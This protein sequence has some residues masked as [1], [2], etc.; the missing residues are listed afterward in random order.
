MASSTDVCEAMHISAAVMQRIKLNFVWA[1]GYNVLGIPLAAGLFYPLY[2]IL[3]P[4]MY[5]GFAM[6]M[7]SVSVVCS[8]LLL[9]IIEPLALQPTKRA[10]S[11]EHHLCMV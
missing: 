1:I 10:A 9:R 8:S 3:I 5:A 7:S 2:N 11:G 6:A 4:P